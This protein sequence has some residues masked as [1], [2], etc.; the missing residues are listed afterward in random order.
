MKI[1][2]LDLARWDYNVSS[3]RQVPLGGSQSA[4]CYLAECLAAAGQEVWVV[5]HTTAPGAYSG[6]NCLSWKTT[7]ESH[8]RSLNLDVVVVLQRAGMGLKLRAALD[9]RTRLI[10]WTGDTPNQAVVQPL[11]DPAERDVYDGIA[12]VSQWQANQFQSRFSIEPSRIGVMPNGVSPAFAALFADGRPILP[13]KTSP[14]IL[15]YTSAPYRGLEVLLDVFPAIR[16]RVPGARL[17]VFSSM[18]MHGQSVE[19]DREKYG[20]LYD[21]CRQME[22]VE[23]IGSLPQPELAERMR[24][25]T[26]LGYPNIYKETGCIAVME[27][28]AAGCH[29]V[30]SDLGALSETTAGFARL[31]SMAQ[32]RS[33]YSEQYVDAAT[34]ILTRQIVNPAATEAHLRKQ[35]EYISSS[36]TWPTRATEWIKWLS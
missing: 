11:T 8:F 35:I 26:M 28:M 2:L 36:C 33:S 9:P 31:I 34:D 23:Y 27:A 18:L 10:L 32:S 6:V 3:V 15:A 25:V 21:R 29:I 20:P 19:K 16:D 13:E 1:A 12:L 4:A 24:R 7:G 17:E 30:T 22:S 5:N 14:P